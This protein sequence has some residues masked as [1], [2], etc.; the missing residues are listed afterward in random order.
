VPLT[1]SH[2]VEAPAARAS[3]SS[4]RRLDDYRHPQ[5]FGPCPKRSELHHRGNEI[6]RPGLR[7]RLL[8]LRDRL[9]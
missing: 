8:G 2:S 5:R 1:S 3:R 7:G 9:R 4:G 6:T